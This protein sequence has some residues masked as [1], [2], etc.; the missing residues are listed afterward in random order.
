VPFIAAFLTAARGF[1]DGLPIHY[2]RKSA[3]PDPEGKNYEWFVAND[4]T[5][6]DAPAGNHLALGPLAADPGLP[7][8]PD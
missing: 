7:Y 1:R 6:K 3:A 2:P 8:W 5:G 4:R